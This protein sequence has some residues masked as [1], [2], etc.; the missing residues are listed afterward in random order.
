[1]GLLDETLSQIRPLDEDAMERAASR[2]KDLYLGIGDLGKMENMVTQFAGVTGEA[3]PAIPKCCTVIACSDHGGI[4]LSPVHHRRHDKGLCGDK[5]GGGQC[6][7]LL[8]PFGHGG[9][10]Y[11]HQCG[12]ER[13]AGSP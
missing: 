3:M 8:C 11:G 4:R 1:M 13:R 6:H 12:Y 2:W 7:G 10:G 9:G 5:G